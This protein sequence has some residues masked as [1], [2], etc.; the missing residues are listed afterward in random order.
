MEHT[1]T[2]LY[3]REQVPPAPVLP[4]TPADQAKAPNVVAVPSWLLPAILLALLLVG[5]ASLGLGAVVLWAV[6]RVA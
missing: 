5:F 2:A 3:S 6:V 1:V 4:P